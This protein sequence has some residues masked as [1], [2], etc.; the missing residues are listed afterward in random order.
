MKRAIHATAEVAYRKAISLDP[1][2]CTSCIISSLVRVL[3]E[4]R[5][6][7]DAVPCLN[8]YL[9]AK[10]ADKWALSSR[11]LSAASIMGAASYKVENLTPSY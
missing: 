2:D 9:K 11:G 7:A 10:P 5:K 3:I 4:E 1:P 8:E 6:F